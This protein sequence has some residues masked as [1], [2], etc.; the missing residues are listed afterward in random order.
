MRGP[1][2]WAETVRQIN[3]LYITDPILHDTVESVIK[4]FD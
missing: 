4:D 2:N 1:L 3:H